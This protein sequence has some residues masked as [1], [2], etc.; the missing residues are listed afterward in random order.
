[1]GDFDRHGLSFA[2]ER[3]IAK[4]LSARRFTFPVPAAGLQTDADNAPRGRAQFE[5]PGQKDVEEDYVEDGWRAISS[6]T[7]RHSAK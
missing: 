3:S 5:L 1:M 2:V 6:K 7:F 4:F